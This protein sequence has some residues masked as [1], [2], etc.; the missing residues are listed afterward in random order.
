[1]G[2]VIH[3]LR[4]CSKSFWTDE[5][6]GKQSSHQPLSTRPVTHPL[7]RP[8][9]EGLAARLMGKMLKG[10]LYSQGITEHGIP[11]T[12]TA[13]TSLHSVT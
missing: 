7:D 12:I 1:M 11:H 5:I 10:E 13:L 4:P 6:T 2:M 9:G 8:G 3:N